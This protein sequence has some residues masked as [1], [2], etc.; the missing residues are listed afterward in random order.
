M[1]F[2]GRSVWGQSQ[3]FTAPHN[4]QS[5]QGTRHASP[6]STLSLP[7]PGTPPFLLWEAKA[8]ATGLSTELWAPLPFRPSLTTVGFTLDDQ[9]L[10]MGGWALP[11]CPYVCRM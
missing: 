10:A 2:Q 7:K 6:P 11:I 4:F 8:L 3:A 5:P 1:S 9:P